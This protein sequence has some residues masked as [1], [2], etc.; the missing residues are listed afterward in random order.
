MRGHQSIRLAF[1][2]ALGLA[3]TPAAPALDLPNFGKVNDRYYRGAQ[4]RADQYDELAEAGV[5]T[6]VDLRDDARRYARQSA[7]RV[8]LRYIN[9]PL[10]D[11]RRPPE[12]AAA[13]FLAIIN[14]PA[15]WPVYVHC[16]G[17]RHR[18]GAM[19]ALYRM[20]ADGW[21]IDRTYREMK[22][23]DFYTRHGHGVYKVYVYDYYRDLKTQRSQT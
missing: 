9:L 11:K 7:E 10:N 6:I 16:A 15:N 13:R 23:Y 18:T 21:D 2:T 14:D 8:G 22:D 1:I 20:T 4:P 19:T 17:G 5:K 3:L 12:D